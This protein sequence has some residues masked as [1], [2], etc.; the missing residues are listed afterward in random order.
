MLAVFLV[1]QDMHFGDV[2]VDPIQM[3]D[4]REIF[5]ESLLEILAKLACNV[6]RNSDSRNVG[7][8]SK[9]ACQRV[10]SI[11]VSFSLLQVDRAIGPEEAV[12]STL[13]AKQAASDDVLIPPL[14]V[15]IARFET[16]ARASLINST[17]SQLYPVRFACGP[18]FWYALD[19]F[20]IFLICSLFAEIASA[21]VQMKVGRLFYISFELQPKVSI[22]G[23]RNGV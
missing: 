14:S 18:Y 3:F 17:I 10:V 20:D 7:D 15:D 19:I 6:V 21:V 1:R 8:R 5:A 12:A 22:N 4:V 2:P 13:A 11:Y 23:K 16:A 9:R